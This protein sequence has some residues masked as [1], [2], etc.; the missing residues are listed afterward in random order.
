MSHR[1]GIALCASRVVKGSDG[2]ARRG[3]CLDHAWT[4]LGPRSIARRAWSG[5]RDERSAA[6]GALRSHADGRLSASTSAKPCV[7]PLTS[8]H[9]F[10]D[11][12][13]RA[14]G[15]EPSRV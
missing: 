3:V 14:K 4:T 15:L 12:L 13:V 5:A 8:G 1:K 7:F 9:G 10:T 2:F 11:T 6:V